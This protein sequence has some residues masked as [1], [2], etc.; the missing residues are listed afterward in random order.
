MVLENNMRIFILAG[1]LESG[2]TT[3]LKNYFEND[4]TYLETDD[5]TLLI[6]CEDG[7]VEY[8][9]D[10]LEKHRV[11]KVV[12]EEEPEDVALEFGQLIDDY[13]PEMVFIEWNLMWD[14]LPAQVYNWMG[15]DVFLAF[16]DGSTLGVYFNNMRQLFVNLLQPA[17]MVLINRAPE[18]ID[19][20]P[21]ADP[22]MIIND[23]AE[24]LRELPNGYY[25]EAFEAVAPYDK[26]ADFIPISEEDFPWFCIDAMN[27]SGD[28]LGKEIEAICEIAFSGE[29]EQGF[30]F[31][32]RRVMVCCADDTQFMGFYCD[33]GDIQVPGN[34]A[35]AK[36]RAKLVDAER[37]G[38]KGNIMFEALSI[39]E[40]ETPEHIVL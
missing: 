22:F 5:T 30:V 16:I 36:I 40:I 12:F 14:T 17:D 11:K 19:L 7:E 20:E 38:L 9:D 21:F 26:S 3:Y 1:M 6:V 27:H 33:C 29:M 37:I 24:Y 18:N 35:F 15:A 13:D 34:N 10:I 25:E 23:Q 28:Y 39:E 31:A 2:K 32:G 8:N 4:D